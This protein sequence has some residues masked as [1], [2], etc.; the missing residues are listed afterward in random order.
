MMKS[1]TA[2]KFL[3]VFALSLSS[4]LFAANVQSVKSGSWDDPSVW[5]TGAVPALGDNVVIK[6]GHFVQSTQINPNI[7]INNLT[8]EATGIL[9]IGNRNFKVNGTSNVSGTF[10]DTDTNGTN[11]FQGKV[12]IG[13]GGIWNTLAVTGNAQKV[14]FG[15]G[16][17]MNGDSMLIQVASFLGNNQTVSGNTQI[18]IVKELW[19]SPGLTI[20]NENTAGMFFDGGQIRGG[21]ATA[22]FV[23]KSLLKY[24]DRN[25]PMT[26]GSVDFSAP[27]NTVIYGRRDRQFVRPTTHYNMVIDDHN[28]ATDENNKILQPGNP[29]IVLNE[30]TINP[31]AELSAEDQ[32]LTI[33]GNTTIRGELFDGKAGG[34]VTFSNLLLDGGKVHGQPWAFGDYVV[35]G[36][37]TIQGANPIIEDGSWD[38]QGPTNVVGT[39]NFR[40]EGGGPGIKQFRQINLA[41]GANYIDVATNGNLIFK[42]QLNIQNG[43]FLMRQDTY[44]ENGFNHVGDTLGVDA[45][46][47]FVANNQEAHSTRGWLLKKPINIGTGVRALINIEEGLYVPTNNTYFLGEDATA[48]FANKGKVIFNE[49]IPKLNAV[50]TDFT[51][52]GN[53]VIMNMVPANYVEL[54]GGDFYHLT[55]NNQ[56]VE[57]QTMF[58][59]LPFQTL[60]TLGDFTLGRNISLNP[61]QFD[62]QVD[63]WGRIYGEIFDNNVDGIVTFGNLEVGRG[64]IDGNNWRKGTFAVAGDFVV[65]DTV[66]VEEADFSVGGMTIIK[67]NGLLLLSTKEGDRSFGGLT[68][69]QDGELL[70]NT[71]G[72]DFVFDGPVE[73]AGKLSLANGICLFTHPVIITETGTLTFEREWGSYNFSKGIINNGTV[74]LGN[75]YFAVSGEVGG[76]AEIALNSDI[77]VGAGDTL[78]NTNSGGFTVGG[79]L[80]GEDEGSYF[81]NRGI[82]NYAPRAPN[83]PMEVGTFDAFTDP[84]NW[85]NFSGTN[86]WQEVETG[87]YRNIG[88]LNGGN[89]KLTGGNIQIYGDIRVVETT[90]RKAQDPFA[91]GVVRIVGTE[92]QHISGDVSGLF[93]ELFVEKPSGKL[94][95]DNDFGITGT[96]L[97]K[98]GILEAY[99]GG[100]FMANNSFLQETEESYVL[101]RVAALR[102]IC[103]GCSNDFGGLGLKIQAGSG[104]AMGPT[105]VIRHTGASYAPGQVTRYYEVIPTNNENLN[106]SIEFGYLEREINGAIEKDLD[107]VVSTDGT[108]FE[109]LGGKNLTKSNL[110]QK[111]KIDQLGIISLAPSSMAIN[112]YPSPFTDGNLN[113]DYVIDE[114]MFV[115][116]RIFDRT[117]RTFVKRS[118]E[119]F[120]GLNTFK[121]EEMQLPAGI[122]FVRI[123]AGDKIGF[124]TVLKITP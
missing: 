70:D 92:D 68:I 13:A 30:L 11:I 16:I 119:S 25:A 96:L 75:G 83:I 14:V 43:A 106:A 62:M 24:H 37:F 66:T 51:E 27:G 60:H 39:S 89:K 12:T 79:I 7:E 117:G 23:N 26:P 78:T 32:F 35:T 42:E 105:R 124:K 22:T 76:M 107:V 59:F 40:I 6:V 118:V 18:Y 49:N 95:L 50:T 29:T 5:S 8:V 15:G 86:G 108:T 56:R 109:V 72:E 17:E 94:I 122:Y 113:I 82:F 46:V 121:L 97:M 73:L 3:L 65:E 71:L 21:D 123:V 84:N 69:E 47:F 85:V 28:I 55:I 104:V 112:A 2:L 45:N 57:N 9:H 100:L 120:G 98:G 31:F 38:V 58:S 110:V 88:F 93:E 61:V 4:Q 103:E 19:V 114:D 36:T 44:F 1:F 87:D 33:Q 53:E 80:N 91:V 115:D 116:L 111:T 101:G 74:A 77:S 64:K 81:I 48:I 54:P 20:T 52:V 34:L 102:D 10:K 67:S 90:V 63:G 41:A 99:N